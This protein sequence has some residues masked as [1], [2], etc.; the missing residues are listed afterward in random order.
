[1]TYRITRT[2]SQVRFYVDQLS[3]MQPEGAQ[4]VLEAGV[5]CNGEDSVCVQT[6]TL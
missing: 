4:A 1:M 3:G 2:K 5:Q 6:A